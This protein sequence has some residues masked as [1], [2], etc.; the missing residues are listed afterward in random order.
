MRSKVAHH[1]VPDDHHQVSIA[2][3]AHHREHACI[4]LQKTHQNLYNYRHQN[5]LH[6]GTQLLV[7]NQADQAIQNM[8]ANL[9][10]A[11]RE[12]QLTIFESHIMYVCET[13]KFKPP[14]KLSFFEI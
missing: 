3:F 5:H 14:L 11:V 6:L 1:D 4:S 8:Q 7:P 12:P 2:G 9:Y 13:Q 10:H